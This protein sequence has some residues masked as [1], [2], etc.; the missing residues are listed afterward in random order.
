MK[1]P[2]Q[3]SGNIV[4]LDTPAVFAFY[5]VKTNAH[6]PLAL[7]CNE[8]DVCIGV[9]GSYEVDPDR[10]NISTLTC[11][12]ICNREFTFLK[13]KD[14][15]SL[16]RDARNIFAEKAIRTLPVLNEH[17][18][19]VGLFG[20]WQAFFLE[21]YK[22]LPYLNYAHGL[23]C[24]AKQA[25]E[26]GYERISTIEF[27]VASGR[28]LINLERYAKE[29]SRLIGI[30]IDVYGF[31][32]GGG[33]F[34]PSDYRDCPQI[35]IEGEYKMDIAALKEKLYNANLIIGDICETTKTF[36][37]K[38]NPA[39]IA[40]IS[41]DVDH[42]KPCVAILDMLLGDDKYFIPMPLIYFDDIP[43]Q[44]QFQGE[45]LAI[46]EFNAK[47]EFIK[48]SPEYSGFN[49]LFYHS[50]NDMSVWKQPNVVSRIK[51]LHRFKHP[52]YASTRKTKNN[53]SIF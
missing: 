1:I 16:Y 27:G 28:G 17:R 20:R 19:P 8:D 43:D 26:K 39:P 33:L 51:Y 11:G 37:E 23:L 36:L 32:S 2:T 48:I 5:I 45:Y 22:T 47:S 6:Y 10:I 52:K 9:I 14:E 4:Y 44:V 21:N 49:T 3:I 30:G 25:K 42:Y 41:I 38:Y 15:D 18:N 40:F 46:K 13:D 29:I 31:D 24:S 34:A 12:E 7:V 35:W 50:E 53:I